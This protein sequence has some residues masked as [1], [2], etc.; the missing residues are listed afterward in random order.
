MMVAEAQIRLV[1]VSTSTID[2]V[3]TLRLDEPIDASDSLLG[4][5]MIDVLARRM[6]VVRL[7]GTDGGVN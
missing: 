7:F 5:T 3:E 2:V 6:S 1:D 4:G